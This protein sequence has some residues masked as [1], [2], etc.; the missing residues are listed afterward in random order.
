LLYWFLHQ[1]RKLLA[2][3]LVLSKRFS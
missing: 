3:K 1:Q 2:T